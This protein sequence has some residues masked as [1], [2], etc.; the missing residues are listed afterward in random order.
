MDYYQGIVAEY[1]AANRAT[2]VNPECLI[3]LEPGDAPAK[4]RHWY[5]DVLAIEP[6]KERAWLCEVTF[7]TTLAALVGRLRA[8]STHWPEIRIALARDSAIPL[9]WQVKPRLFIPAVRRSLLDA[10]LRTLAGSAESEMPTPEIKH[11]EDIV[12]WKYRTW[13]RRD[14]DVD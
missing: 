2:F 7:S 14:E 9:T 13:D 8:W 6:G 12:P 11:L 10:K 1:L 5:C 4:H 3:Q